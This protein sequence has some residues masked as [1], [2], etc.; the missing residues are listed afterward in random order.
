MRS[1]A[2]RSRPESGTPLDSK[3]LEYLEFPKITARLAEHCT[4][5]MGR[6]LAGTLVPSDD[7]DEVLRRQRLTAE[8]KRLRRIKPSFALGGAADIT[9]LAH[10]AA[11]GAQLPAS[12][13]LEALSFLRSAR[14]TRH[15]IIPLADQVPALA[16]VAQRI[17]EFGPL[18]AEIDRA[19]SPRGEILDTASP[20]LSVLRRDVQVAHDRLLDRV[21]R[22]LNQTLARGYA[23]E[24]II[25]ERDGRYVIPIK[26]DSRSHVPGVVHDLSSSGAT[27]FVEPLGAVELG[28]GWREARLLEERE[29]ERVL[30]RL[31]GLLGAEAGAIVASVRAL[32]EIDLTLAKADFAAAID[33]PLPAEGEN[34]A[35]IVEAPSELRLQSA[36]HPLLTGEV[37]PISL[38]A[39]GEQRGVLITGPN[40][41]GKTVALKSVGLLTLMAQAGLPVPA[42]AGTQIPVYATI[43]ADIG[44]EQSIEQSLSTFS[45]HM[46]NIIRILEA[47]GPQ[48]LVLLD[49]LGAGTDPSEGS[50]LGRAILKQLLGLGATFVATTHHGELKIF[51]HET[52]G[53]INASVEFDHETLAPTYRLM[54]GLPGRSNA[55]AIAER[56]G[57]PAPVL[58]DARAA[59]TPGEQSMER[60]LEELQRDRSA[61]GDARSAEEFARHEAESIRDQLR[62]RLDRLDAERDEVLAKTQMEMERQLGALRQSIRAAEKR[63]ASGRKAE[64]EQ[65]RERAAGAQRRLERVRRERRQP[66][67]HRRPTPQERLDPA[68]IRPGAVVHLRGL[69][70]PGEALTAVDADGM[71]AVQLG[72]LRTRVRSDQVERLGQREERR[73]DVR[74]AVSIADPGSRI[75]VRG[76]TLDEAL[77]T[78]ERFLDQAFRAGLSRVEVV[79]GKGTGTLREAVR[80]LLGS[81]PLVGRYTPASQEEGG[82]GVTIVHLAL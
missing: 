36:R 67:S 31:S 61:T 27:A 2:T 34:Q 51:A 64:I 50:A 65:A 82:E 3:T 24:S 69:E 53:L 66:Q 40:T 10:S 60:L 13:L 79:H 59:Y 1:D 16:A 57:L 17:G 30:R 48:S 80:Q 68:S 76:Q 38:V 44:D 8:G 7:V 70:Q 5:P 21:Q 43:A 15:H 23:Q 74:Y 33:A 20:T 39:G 45:S 32:A 11:R 54:L 12:E 46:R 72:S 73:G 6:E 55:I 56:L 25:T 78:V 35:W 4:S 62:Q 42:E 75:E 18:I 19:L 9:P 71:L 28:N 63:L 29:V 58:A 14:H 77:P 41:G 22:I 37:V 52:P 47:A 26:V 81:H 49:E